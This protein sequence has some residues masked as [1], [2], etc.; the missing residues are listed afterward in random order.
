M[1]AHWGTLLYR[2][3]IC[4]IAVSV[5]SLLSSLGVVHMVSGSEEVCF[6]ALGVS[7]YSYV[8]EF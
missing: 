4:I 8:T 7:Y 3:S 2:P 6:S 1:H 5:I